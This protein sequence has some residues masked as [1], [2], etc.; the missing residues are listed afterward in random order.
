VLFNKKLA[1]REPMKW[2][3]WNNPT[4]KNKNKQKG[5]KSYAHRGARTKVLVIGD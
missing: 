2:A 4:E 1:V 5:K 3:K